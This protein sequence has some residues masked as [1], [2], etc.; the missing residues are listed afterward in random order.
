MSFDGIIKMLTQMVYKLYNGHYHL[1]S[2]DVTW[3]S[4]RRFRFHRAFDYL[5]KI[6]F[7]STPKLSCKHHWP[8]YGGNHQELVR[9][10][11]YHD[12]ITMLYTVKTIPVNVVHFIQYLSTEFNIA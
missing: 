11:R 10:S 9:V 8:F 6:L 5:F 12:A 4:R 2:F 1:M 3:E 7:R